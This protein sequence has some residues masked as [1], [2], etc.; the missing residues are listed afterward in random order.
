MNIAF[1]VVFPGHVSAGHCE[2]Y[3]EE[4]SRVAEWRC[5]EPLVYLVT[6]A[7][8]NAVDTVRADLQRQRDQRRLT[9][10][11]VAV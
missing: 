6:P 9:Y 1:R 4:L 2:S 7:R 3:L 5:V 10:E 8:K 11:E